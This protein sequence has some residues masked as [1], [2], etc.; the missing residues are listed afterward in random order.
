MKIVGF[1][2]DDIDCPFT[3]VL[4]ELKFKGGVL[5]FKSEKGR[6]YHLYLDVLRDEKIP[7]FYEIP[8]P[9]EYNN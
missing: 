5:Q 2:K 6:I 3:E 8:E 1:T 9:N 7:K 4:A